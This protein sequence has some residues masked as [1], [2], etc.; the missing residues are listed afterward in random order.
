MSLDAGFDRDHFFS[1]IW[2][3]KL[4]KKLFL[5]FVESSKAFLS[6]CTNNKSELNFVTVTRLPRKTIESVSGY[7]RP[8][9]SGLFTILFGYRTFFCNCL[10]PFGLS[11]TTPTNWKNASSVCLLL[12]LSFILFPI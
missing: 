4:S 6:S 12:S 11:T 10:C 8:Y 2:C 7:A 1:S 9:I 3:Q 5:N